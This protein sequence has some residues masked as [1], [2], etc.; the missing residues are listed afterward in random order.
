MNNIEMA[1]SYLKQAEERLKHA[2]EALNNNY[3]YVIRQSQEGVELA[4]KASLRIVGI[5]PP[6]FHDVGPIL[7]RNANIFPEWFRGEI[8]NM[9][10]ISR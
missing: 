5:E 8:D 3:A 7:R 6:K 10:S 2:K 4:L 9:A 1:R